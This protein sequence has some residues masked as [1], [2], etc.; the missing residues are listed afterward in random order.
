ML[1]LTCSI[2]GLAGQMASKLRIL[3][4]ALDYMISSSVPVSS[5]LAPGPDAA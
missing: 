2:Q 4:D 1:T 3:T 5:S